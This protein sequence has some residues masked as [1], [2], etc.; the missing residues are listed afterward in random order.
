MAGEE[1]LPLP[2]GSNPSAARGR[3]RTF[4]S[5]AFETNG[6]AG[7]TRQAAAVRFREED[8]PVHQDGPGTPKFILKR[9]EI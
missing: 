7:A 2:D 6:V 1:S 5:A 9:H 4:G 8:A 3:R